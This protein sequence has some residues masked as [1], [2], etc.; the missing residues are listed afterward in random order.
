MLGKSSSIYRSQSTRGT[1]ANA[2][3]TDAVQPCYDRA[4]TVLQPRLPAKRSRPITCNHVLTAAVARLFHVFT[5][6]YHFFITCV[7]RVPPVVTRGR[8]FWAAQNCLPRVIFLARVGAAV[9]RPYHGLDACN[10]ACFTFTNFSPWVVRDAT[11]K[12][13]VTGPLKKQGEET[14]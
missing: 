6:L 9:S 12:G 13:S 7:P 10:S 4:M 3:G 14:R 1:H 11:A 8:Q 5:R 2:R